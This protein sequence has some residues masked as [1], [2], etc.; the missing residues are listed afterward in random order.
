MT[1]RRFWVE[2][3]HP[4]IRFGCYVTAQSADEAL[5]TLRGVI[6]RGDVVIGEEPTRVAQVADR[7]RRQPKL[8]GEVHE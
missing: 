4:A 7:L 2:L 5:A 6:E 3:A 8:V 1:M